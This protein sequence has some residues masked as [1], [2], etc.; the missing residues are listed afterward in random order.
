MIVTLLTSIDATLKR[1]LTAQTAPSIASD[2]DLDG[3][4]GNPPVRFM[5][6]AWTGASYKDKPFSACPPELLDLVAESLDWLAQ[7]AETNNELTVGG[8][9][10]AQYKRLDAARARGWAKRLR[11]GWKSTDQYADDPLL[12]GDPNEIDPFGGS[13]VPDDDIPF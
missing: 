4:F 2:N 3:K 7:K 8:K 9:P 11:N 1:M 12:G 5:P 13:D 6:K 10:V